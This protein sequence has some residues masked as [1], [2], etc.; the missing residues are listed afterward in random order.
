MSDVVERVRK[1]INGLGLS[2]LVLRCENES[3]QELWEQ[4][5]RLLADMNAARK[6]ASE[7]A[8]QP[9]R[10]KIAAL[11][12]MYATILALISD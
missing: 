2:E 10:E 5:Q 11:D 6:E 9:F 3:L 4:K 1:H 8:A 12:E 7:A